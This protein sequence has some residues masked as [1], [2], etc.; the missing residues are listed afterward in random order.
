MRTGTGASRES[1]RYVVPIYD[2]TVGAVRRLDERTVEIALDPARTALAFAPG[3]FVF[4]AFGGFDG[5]Q[6]HP[7]SI[8][9]GGSDLQLELTIKA[10]GDYTGGLVE[11]VRAG[12]PAKVSGPFGGFDYR[13]GGPEQIWIAGGIGVTPFMSWLRSLDA[14]FNRDVDFHYSVR[15]PADAVY[16]DEIQAIAAHHPSLRV[17]AALRER[18]AADRRGRAGRHPARRTRRSTCAARRR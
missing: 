8:S 4:V 11:G 3:Q 15:S 12:V 13:T 2:Y 10:T 14:G 6:R 17:H 9:G 7:F 18:R 1:A 5:W 16:R